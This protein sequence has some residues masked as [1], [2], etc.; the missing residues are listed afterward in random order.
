MSD[1][2]T[3][4]TGADIIARKLAASGADRAFGIPGGEVLALLEALERAGISFHL[5]KHENA[6]GFMAEGVWHAKPEGNRA[7]AILLATVGPG[8]ANATN[9]IANAMQ[10]RV[11]LIFLTGCIDGAEADTYTHQVFDHQQM[12]RPIVKASFRANAGSLD[13]VMDKALTIAFEGQ[14]GPVHIDV[15]IAV[16]ENETDEIARPLPPMVSPAMQRPGPELAEILEAL[17]GAE[18][19]LVIAGVDAVNDGAS[20]AITA[21]CLM[22]NIPIVTTYKGKGLLDES[23]ELSLGGHGL[24]PKSDTVVLPLVKRADVV[25]LAGYDPIEM[26]IGWRDP[27]A[28]DA[29]VIDVTPQLRDHGVHRVTHT[30]RGSISGTLEQLYAAMDVR[31]RWPNDEAATARAELQAM[32]TGF[33]TWGP[34]QAFEML[35]DIL[36]DDTVMTADAGA[37]RILV[38]QVW[39]SKQPHAVLQSTALCTMGCAVPLAAGFKLA[40][41]DAPVI[42]FV[43]DAGME[44]GLGELSTLRDLKTPVII[45]VMV[46]EELALIEIKQRRSQRPNAGVEFSGTDFPSVARAMGGEGYWIDDAATL[47]QAATEALKKDTFTVLACRIGRHA[48]DGTF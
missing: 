42:A 31:P 22:H 23:H 48:Y 12:L 20:E 11:P 10:D 43:G 29:K 3:R 33:K 35:S 40:N 34:G 45:C 25:I 2:N 19:P 8:V 38:S 5:A 44:M 46:D 30:L 24:S 7:P 27:F 47:A 4:T 32:F 39:Q 36:P 13:A 26:R 37:H 28:D 1:S 16:A 41:P 14:P 17:N 21:L 15:P 9:V 18:R 6:A